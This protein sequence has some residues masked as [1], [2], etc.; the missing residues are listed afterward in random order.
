MV[1]ILLNPNVVLTDVTARKM[2][3]FQLCSMRGYQNGITC[4]MS[5]HKQQ[6]QSKLTVSILRIIVCLHQTLVLLVINLIN[7]LLQ[8]RH[9]ALLQG[10]ILI[11]QLK[12]LF[13]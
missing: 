3:L 4:D 9:A 10:Q 8:G 7:A 5:A 6:N 13:P 1:L 12:P 11:L 2:Q